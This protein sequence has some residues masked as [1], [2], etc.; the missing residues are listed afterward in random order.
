MAQFASS[1]W[2]DQLWAALRS[3]EVARR[4]GA[5]WTFG[6]LVMVIEA[7]TDTSFN[8]TAAMQLD[9]HE[10]EARDLRSVESAATD[11]VPFVLRA[12]YDRWKQIF[13][14]GSGIVDAVLQGRVQFKGDLPTLM[15]HRGLLDAIAA[16]AGR[17]ATTFPDEAATPA[18]AAR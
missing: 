15:R 5:T 14:D 16:A 7:Q 6:P 4:E 2:I 10:G 9:L 3:D 11:R 17:T 12:T 13:T 1:E 18:G 8:Q